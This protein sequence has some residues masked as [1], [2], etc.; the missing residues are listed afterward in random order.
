VTAPYCASGG[1]VYGPASN[2]G[3]KSWVATQAARRLRW[4]RSDGVSTPSTVS[5]W[6]CW[7]SGPGLARAVAAAKQAAGDTGF[8]L[9]PGR[10]A[11][12]VRKLAEAPARPPAT[13]W[14][15]ASGAS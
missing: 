2:F 8:G 1:K 14:S 7:T 11:L 13:P 9:R 3:D 6:P 5:F 10:E 12:I 15:S 4:T